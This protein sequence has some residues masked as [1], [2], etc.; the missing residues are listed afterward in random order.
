MQL[1]EEDA[2]IQWRKWMDKKLLYSNL[3]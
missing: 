1:K 2:A 3:V